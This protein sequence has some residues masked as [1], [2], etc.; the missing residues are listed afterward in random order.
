MPLFSGLSGNLYFSK[1]KERHQRMREMARQIS[2]SV[3]RT[4][5]LEGLDPRHEGRARSKFSA[6]EKSIPDNTHRKEP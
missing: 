1:W 2:L 3:R 6:L 4:V 5:M